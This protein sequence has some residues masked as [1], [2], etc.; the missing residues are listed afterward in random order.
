[1]KHV[2]EIEDIRP[3]RSLFYKPT[4]CTK[5]VIGQCFTIPDKYNRYV[6]ISNESM[7]TSEYLAEE[8]VSLL[9]ENHSIPADTYR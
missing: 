3:G 2:W 9:N 6:L 1:M 4:D 8:L 5:F 7:V